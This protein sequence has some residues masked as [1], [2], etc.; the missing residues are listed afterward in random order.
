[1][2]LP[3]SSSILGWLKGPPGL[4]TGNSVPQSQRA[5]F[6]GGMGLGA[7]RQQKQ[8][9]TATAVTMLSFDELLE[10]LLGF[11]LHDGFTGPNICREDEKPADILLVLENIPLLSRRIETSRPKAEALP[12]TLDQTRA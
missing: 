10:V 6:Q 7:G 9:G 11:L 8:P 1:M 2:R 4:L 5:S 12:P 3:I